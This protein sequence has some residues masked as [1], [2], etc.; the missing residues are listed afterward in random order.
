MVEQEFEEQVFRTAVNVCKDKPQECSSC[1]EKDIMLIY[2]AYGI[3]CHKCWNL[4]L[5]DINSKVDLEKD[6]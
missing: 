6:L 5:N 4:Y 1:H 2:T 3:Y